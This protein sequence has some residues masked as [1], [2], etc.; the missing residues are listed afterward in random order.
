MAKKEKEKKNH[1]VAASPCSS[2]PLVTLADTPFTVSIG[3]TASQA[4]VDFVKV[5]VIGIPVVIVFPSTGLKVM[6]LV[7][8]VSLVPAITSV[9][10]Q[11]NC[12]LINLSCL[13]YTL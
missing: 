6:P 3:R 10:D 1:V 12:Q 11:I 7:P 2:E 13:W 5:L 9:S 4:F 8:P